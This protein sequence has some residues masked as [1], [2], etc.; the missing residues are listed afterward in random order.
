MRRSAPILIACLLA[1]T[2]RFLNDRLRG[3]EGGPSLRSRPFAI[4]DAD[5]AHWAFQP[6]R[7]A[8]VPK[9]THA[10]DHLLQVR[11]QQA[12]LKPNPPATPR[13]QVRRAYLDL[14]GLP[15]SPE[16]VTEFER[17]TSTAL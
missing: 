14:W 8:V 17:Y 1:L 7:S 6:V 12:G 2:G 13:E 15:P 10:I 9:G 4:T 5:R 3:A 11:R 16:A